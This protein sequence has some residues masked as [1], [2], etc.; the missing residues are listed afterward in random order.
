MTKT[1]ET[2]VREALERQH[3]IEDVYN[4]VNGLP[5]RTEMVCRLVRVLDDMSRRRALSIFIEDERHVEAWF[6]PLDDA[7]AELKE[8]LGIK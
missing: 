5:S 4:K 6:H 1:L 2:Q 3:G 7:L 8:S